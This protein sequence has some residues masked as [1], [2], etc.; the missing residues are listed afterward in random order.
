MY[1]QF[2]DDP[3]IIPTTR[4]HIFDQSIDYMEAQHATVL[5]CWLS[6]IIEAVETKRDRDKIHDEL[7]KKTIYKYFPIKKQP[8]EENVSCS[9][10]NDPEQSDEEKTEELLR[11]IFQ[12][13][14]KSKPHWKRIT[15]KHKLIQLINSIKSKESQQKW[16]RSKS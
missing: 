7:L 9:Q 8:K 11:P 4:R 3:Y 16:K 10:Q 5:R 15:G 14:P 13:T 12:T 1:E 6:S 2:E